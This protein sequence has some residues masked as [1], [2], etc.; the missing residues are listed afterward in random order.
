MIH[1]ISF[2]PPEK[3]V[4]CEECKYIYTRVNNATDTL[5]YIFMCD[6]DGERRVAQRAVVYEDVGLPMLEPQDEIK[7]CEVPM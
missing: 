4:E 3:P 2:S 1:G 6:I 5:E 7:I